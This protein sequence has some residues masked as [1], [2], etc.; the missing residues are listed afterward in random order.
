MNKLFWIA[1]ALFS[2]PGCTT[3]HTGGTATG[4]PFEDTRWKL[5]SLTGIT[6]LPAA[7]KDMFARFYKK[8]AYAYAGCN[9]LVGNYSLQGNTLKVTN[10]SSTKAACPQQFM[11]AE[12]QLSE[13][14]HNSTG[15]KIVGSKMLLM[16]D[17]TV[18]AEFEA[19][20]QK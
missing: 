7:D 3:S 16:R 2:V 6:Q 11:D 8:K 5:T 4:A 20:S 10:L 13:A 17:E 14:L 15:F 12:T 19:V 18:V 1:L 9:N